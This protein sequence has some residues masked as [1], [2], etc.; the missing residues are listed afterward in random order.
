MYKRK[1]VLVTAAGCFS[2]INI[3]KSLKS[4]NKYNVIAAD[5]SPFSAGILRADRGYLVPKEDKDGLFLMRLLEICKKEKVDILIPGFDT[6]LP[7]ILGRKQDLE[8]LGVKVLIGNETLISIGNDKYELQ[9]FLAKHGFKSLKTFVALDKKIALSELRFPVVIKPRSGWGQRGFFVVNNSEELDYFL[10][11]NDKCGFESIIQE[12]INDD[13]G[14]F[15]NSVSVAKDLDILG[16]I[17]IKRDIVKG[18]SRRM[19]ID[20]FPELSS[21]MI[22]IAKAIASPG[23]INFQCRLKDGDPYVF[24]INSRFSTTNVVRAACG[25]NEVDIL[26]E[27]FLF[28]KKKYISNY[29]R[30]V[31][32]VYLDYVYLDLERFEKFNKT[33]FLKNGGEIYT[34][35]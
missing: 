18:E 31:A 12:Y 23:P 7:Y 26:T 35:L 2:A 3:I 8:S 21:Q 30:A 33:G 29:R 19:I 28:G 13:E 6:E 22:K 27:N 16:A 25:Y 1:T 14:E 24:E 11:E 20:K 4:T 32:V 9:T 34:W 17:C 15:T 5:I 10:K